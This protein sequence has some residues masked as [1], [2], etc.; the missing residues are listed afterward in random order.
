VTG[1]LAGKRVVVTRAMDQAEELA[2][3]LRALG[4]EAILLPMI[5]IVAAADP[6]PLREAA[7]Q[8]DSYD[9][10]IF[11]SANAVLFFAAELPVPRGSCRSRIAC[12]GAATSEIAEKEG[13]T[14]SLVP[15]RFV[16]ESLLDSLGTEEIKGRRILIPSAAVTREVLPKELRRRGAVVD[17]VEAYRN[18]LPAD[19][20]ERAA[21]VF[22]DP[23][24][25]WA[26]FTSASAFENLLSVMDREKL[27]RVRIGTIGP[28]TSDAVRKHGF[29][30]GA[31]ATPHSV[32]GLVHALC[33]E[34]AD[35]TPSS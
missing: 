2:A 23:Y 16:S 9:W 11:S 25:D 1:N 35:P 6:A 29:A 4:A 18:I 19:A 10:I 5:A 17:V 24:P 3:P 28:V 12:I 21:A 27:K 33:G 7:A 20:G 26:T 15:E 13:F 32:A 30:V 34:A 31:E 8:C 22:R 14:V